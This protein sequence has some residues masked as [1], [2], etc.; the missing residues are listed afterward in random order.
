MTAVEV[1]N[2]EATYFTEMMTHDA[3]GQVLML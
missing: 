3:S 1:Y 2:D